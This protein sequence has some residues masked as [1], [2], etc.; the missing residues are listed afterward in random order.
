MFRMRPTRAAALAR[1]TPLALLA[2]SLVVAACNNGS[3]SSGY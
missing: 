1:L 2:L 3:G